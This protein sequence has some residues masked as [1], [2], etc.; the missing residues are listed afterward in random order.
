MAQSYMTHTREGPLMHFQFG[1]RWYASDADYLVEIDPGRCCYFWQEYEVRL[2]RLCG[3]NDPLLLNTYTTYDRARAYEMS[4]YVH[5]AVARY[6][7]HAQQGAP[8]SEVVEAQV[9]EPGDKTTAK[10]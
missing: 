1:G 3:D 6:K 8:A 10:E 2:Y 9:V 5:D 7:E 4:R